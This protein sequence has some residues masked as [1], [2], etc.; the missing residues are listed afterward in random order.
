MVVNEHNPIE[1]KHVVEKIELILFAN[2]QC[3]VHPYLETQ[4]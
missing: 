4:I 2:Y 1:K 3:T